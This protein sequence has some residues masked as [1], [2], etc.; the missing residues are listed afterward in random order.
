MDLRRVKSSSNLINQ[1]AKRSYRQVGTEYRGALYRG[2]TTN[3]F[4]KNSLGTIPSKFETV[5]SKNT[6]RPGDGFGNHGIR[7]ND[8]RENSPGPGSYID[9]KNETYSAIKTISGS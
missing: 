4:T 1:R 2:P 8:K 7:F 9:P 3:A 6:N 5:L